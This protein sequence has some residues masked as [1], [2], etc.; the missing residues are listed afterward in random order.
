[1]PGLIERTQTN[2]AVLE[3]W[4]PG[5]PWVAFLAEDPP[6]RSPTSVCLKVVDPWFEN[7]KP[8]GQRAFIAE[9]CSFLAQEGVAYDIQSYREAPPGLRVWCGCTV[10]EDDIKVLTGWLDY[11]FQRVKSAKVDKT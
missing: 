9:I 3:R 1:L 10:E 6:A 5:T 8:E 4:V 2:F 7:L 11:A